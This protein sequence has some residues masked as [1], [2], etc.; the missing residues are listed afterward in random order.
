MISAYTPCNLFLDGKDK[1]TGR[2]FINNNGTLILLF[3]VS[4]TLTPALA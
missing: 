2:V 4:Y 3:T 1:L